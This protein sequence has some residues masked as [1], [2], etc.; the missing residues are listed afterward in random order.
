MCDNFLGTLLDMEK[1]RD[2]KKVREALKEKNIKSLLWL[3][4][5]PSSK[6]DYM[7]QTAYT[8]TKEQK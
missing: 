2:D 3:Q 6:V 1:S 8:M 4:T 5:H 7:P